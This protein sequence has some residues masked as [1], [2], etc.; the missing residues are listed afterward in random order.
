MA[1]HSF[2]FSEIV[3][4]PQMEILPSM[5]A[6]LSVEGQDWSSAVE[7]LNTAVHLTS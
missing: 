3:E 7:V 5:F 4:Y 2:C 6:Y 1:C